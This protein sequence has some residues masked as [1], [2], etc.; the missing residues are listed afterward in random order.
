VVL[1]GAGKRYQPCPSCGATLDLT[2]DATALGN[3]GWWCRP[4]AEAEREK[5]FARKGEEQCQTDHS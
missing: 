5:H 1:K 2:R 4:C 3:G